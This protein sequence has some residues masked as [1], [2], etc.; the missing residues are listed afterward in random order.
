MTKRLKGNLGVLPFG[1]QLP[2]RALPRPTG[3]CRMS[4]APRANL[5]SL[6]AAAGVNAA[7]LAPVSLAFDRP[8][9]APRPMR[10]TTP[11]ETWH[12]GDA[13]I[14]PRAS[15]ERRDDAQAHCRVSPA[16]ALRCASQTHTYHPVRECS[17]AYP[18]VAR[19][20]SDS[21]LGPLLGGHALVTRPPRHWAARGA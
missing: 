15:S 20:V 4:V 21:A 11:A 9:R 17:S 2:S 16:P 5:A 8:S 10:A 6:R 14:S 13:W 3:T 12:R 18:L 1:D 7:V 19:G